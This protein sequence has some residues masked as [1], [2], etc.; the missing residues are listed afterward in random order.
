MPIGPAGGG[1]L[2]DH[3]PHACY[4]ACHLTG[5]QAT[6]V[7]CTLTTGANG[8]DHAAQL[9]LRLANGSTAEITLSWY[10]TTRTS[11]YELTGAHGTV[12][13]RNGLLEFAAPT[14]T[15]R[16]RTEDHS[17][18]GHARKRWTD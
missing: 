4:L 18:G 5:Q 16:V 17:A 12:R 8:A 10:G 11:S 13:L 3:G 15:S 9:G 7:S 1:I 2:Y 6:S 14:S